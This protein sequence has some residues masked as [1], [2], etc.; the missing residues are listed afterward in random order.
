[1]SERWPKADDLVDLGD[2]GASRIAHVLGPDGRA[3]WRVRLVDG[4]LV[5]VQTT[6]DLSHWVARRAG[7]GAGW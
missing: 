2:Q 7:V 3:A 1:M 6:P 4:R 5:S